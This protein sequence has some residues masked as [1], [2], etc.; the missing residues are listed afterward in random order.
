MRR[1]K[2]EYSK[3]RFARQ[4]L[5][6]LWHNKGA[7]RIHT[8]YLI[9]MAGNVH[10]QS[11]YKQVLRDLG[12]IRD[13]TGTCRAGAASALLSFDRRGQASLRGGVPKPIV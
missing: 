13:W 7:A 8:D 3:V 9:M 2:G 11:D 5:N 6:S 1:S 4:F 10:Q 12:V